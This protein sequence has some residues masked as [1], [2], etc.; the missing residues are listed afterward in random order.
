[1]KKSR[2][3]KGN[4]S[5][6]KPILLGALV[7]WLLF[8]A[9][10]LAFTVILYSGNDPTPKTALFSLIS[11]MTAGALGSLINKKLF[12]V[13]AAKAPLFSAL[14]SAAVFVCIS[15]ISMGKISVGTLISAVCFMLICTLASL[16]RRKKQRRH[17]PSHH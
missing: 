11:F 5:A 17:T 14:L 6:F 7:I 12:G 3:T 10:S 4:S 16:K 13:G 1:M 9:I 8:F 15:A 2:Y